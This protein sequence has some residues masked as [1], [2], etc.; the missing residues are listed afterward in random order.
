M[1]R[2]AIIAAIS[3]LA[4][5]A[6]GEKQHASGHGS[7][8]QP[9]P[10][11]ISKSDRVYEDGIHGGVLGSLVGAV[12][13]KEHHDR[14]RASEPR[15]HQRRCDGGDHYFSKAAHAPYVDERVELMEQGIDYCPDNPA[16]HNDLGL[17]LLLWGDLPA[18]RNHLYRAL[19]LDS[20]YQPARL[21]LAYVP[22]GYGG[23][24]MADDQGAKSGSGG[25]VRYL[26]RQRF[27]EHQRDRLHHIERK[28]RRRE[29]I[30]KMIERNAQYD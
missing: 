15:Y 11:D 18:A 30:E 28:E 20:N 27:L 23:V 22:N 17:A 7:S 2:Y 14:I 19:E 26:P 4:G 9:G 1:K 24:E 25:K 13:D 6:S 16:A 3:L 8:I 29:H 10:I 5:C 12:L 21:N